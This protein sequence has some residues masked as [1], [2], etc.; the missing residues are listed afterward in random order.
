MKF[1]HIADIHFDSPFANLSDKEVLGEIKRLEQRK[2]LKKVVNYIKEN[3]VDLLFISGDLY[4][5]KYI[6]KSTIEYINNLFKEIENTKIFIS[7]GNHDPYI[8]NS[9]YREF[10][11]NKNVYIFKPELQ[12]VELEDIDIYGYGFGDFY[13]TNCGIEE[14]EIKNKNKKN[15]LVIHSQ[16]DGANIEEKQYNSI[17]KKI[18]EEKGFDYVAVGHIHKTDYNLYENP[19]IVYSGSLV[20]LGFDEIGKH[21]MIS[22][23]IK[24]DDITIDFIPLSEN[25]FI[26]IVIDISEIL[27]KEELIEKINSINVEGGKLAKIILTGKRKFEINKYDIYKLIVNENIIKIND[28]TT[29]EYNL[30]EMVNNT[31]L[32]GLFIKEIL[33]KKENCNEEEL[34]IIDKAIEITFEA[35]E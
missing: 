10:N 26:E 5:Q 31:T 4:E 20:S 11:W 13:C 23:D 16:I 34:D 28:N 24:E 9:Y 8:K 3:K 6:R 12:C 25:D 21:G 32:K 17:S 22:G 35:L 2:V 29:L 18:L 30:E 14:L 1:V 7:P 33:K 19:K 27:S 15:I